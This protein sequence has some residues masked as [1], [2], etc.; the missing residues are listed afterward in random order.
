VVFRFVFQV[1]G[2]ADYVK[3]VISR[4]GLD[5]FTA[6]FFHGKSEALVEPAYTWRHTGR[7]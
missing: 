4:A 2:S 1:S 3:E 7:Q 5:S 6:I